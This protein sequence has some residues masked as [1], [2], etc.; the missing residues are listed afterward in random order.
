MSESLQRLA[1]EWHPTRNG[2]LTA[3]ELNPNS[4]RRV[5][6]RC[7]RGHEWQAE[8]SA[9]CLSGSGCPV[10]EGK[11][12]LRG[13][14]DLATLAP[15]VAARWSE[16]NG[17]LHPDMVTPQSGKRVWWRCAQ[18]HE[19]RAAVRDRAGERQSGCPVCAGRAAAPT[20]T[21]VPYPEERLGA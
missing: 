10:C 5:W 1:R 8:V 11:T 17:A 4:R 14:N 19:Y 13:V 9:R 7:E 21:L 20:L 18:G 6:W 12:V 3:A 16:R 2:A 15:E